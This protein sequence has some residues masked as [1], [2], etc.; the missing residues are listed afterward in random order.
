MATRS[1][2]IIE[3]GAGYT[4]I[5]PKSR[6]WQTHVVDHASREAL[7]AKYSGQIA[8]VDLAAVDTSAIEEVDTVW[9]GGPL[10]E[11]IPDH[12]MRKIDLIIAS[13]VLEHMPDL[14]GF[15][16]SASRLVKPEGVIAV[17]LPDRRLC[18]DFYKPW[19]TTGDLLDAYQRRLQRHTVK[20]AFNHMAYSASAE[21]KLAWAPGPVQRPDLMDPFATA[22]QVVNQLLGDSD[23]AYADYH[24]WQF[25]PSS[26]RLII[27]E[28]AALGLSEWSVQSLAVTGSFE[29]FVRLAR[30]KDQ[31]LPSIK[32]QALRQDLL[33]AQLLE[34]R[35]QIEWLLGRQVA[36]SGPVSP[37]ALCQSRSV[38]PE[39]NAAGL[40]R[41]RL[42]RRLWQSLM[43][44]R[45][46]A[47]GSG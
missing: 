2:Q 31:N 22:S 16:Q 46:G 19:S 32:L 38:P 13:H 11:A 8:A 23:Q 30:G 4:P 44:R 26:F 35:E 40:T 28:L 47:T 10:H 1:D 15:L 42:H 39:G 29:F 45:E 37:N 33:M 43:G 24:A 36:S 3:I 7:R 34:A 12:L 25:T 17:A 6:G 27:L 20:T 21:G 5:A 18:F 14:I 9:Q 41:A